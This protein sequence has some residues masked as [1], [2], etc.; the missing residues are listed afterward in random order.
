MR[1]G[2]RGTVDD[3]CAQSDRQSMT[4]LGAAGLDHK[5][6]V[7]RRHADSEAMSPF[8]TQF[9]GLVGSFHGGRP[10]FDKW[11]S[12]RG[13]TRGLE[14]LLRH[15]QRCQRLMRWLGQKKGYRLIRPC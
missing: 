12:V 5:P 6:A 13:Q 7:F 11:L 14:M 3:T 4:T 10:S 15:L 9:A 2:K 1:T 8:A